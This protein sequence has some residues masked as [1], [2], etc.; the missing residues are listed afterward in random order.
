MV[1][2]ATV[3]TDFD[4]V[5]HSYGRGWQDGSI[6]DDPIPGAFDAIRQL[7]QRYAV[8]VFTSRDVQQVT[9]WLTSYGIRCHADPHGEIKFWDDQDVVLVT[10][11]KILAICYIDDRAIRFL[12]WP[13]AL[14]AL[15]DLESSYRKQASSVP[16]SP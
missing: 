10:N 13:Q 16:C 8:A 15:E 9:G 14:S 6:Y 1:P 3:A 2:V 7:Q 5:I 12:N 4:G 11:R